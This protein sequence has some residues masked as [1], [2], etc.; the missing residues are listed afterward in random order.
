MSEQSLAEKI[1]ARLD[2]YDEDHD[3]LGCDWTVCIHSSAAA[4]RAVLD[5]CE[6]M[7]REATVG[8]FIADELE[9]VVAE[10]LGINGDR[11]SS[12]G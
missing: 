3:T 9:R 8:R 7:R 6:A 10:A 4:L 5:K 1:R 11:S 12:D 2:W